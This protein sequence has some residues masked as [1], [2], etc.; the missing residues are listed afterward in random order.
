MKF[1]IDGQLPEELSPWLKNKFGYDVFHVKD[2]NLQFAENKKVFR[3][4]L[5]NATR[6]NSFYVLLSLIRGGF[7]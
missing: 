3:S 4:H 7:L 2:F 1:L 5:K 6:H